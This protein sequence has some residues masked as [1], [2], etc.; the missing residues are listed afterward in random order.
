MDEQ[1]I[2][3]GDNTELVEQLGYSFDEYLDAG[4]YQGCKSVIEQVRDL[5]IL[6]AKLLEAELLELPVSLF[7]YGY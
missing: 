3:E 1:N 5:D 4:N 2:K 6:S 7:R